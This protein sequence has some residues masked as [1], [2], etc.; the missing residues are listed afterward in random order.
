MKKFLKKIWAF[1]V[2]LFTNPEQWIENNIVPSIEVVQNIK[3]ALD[4]KIAILLTGLIPGQWDD[5]IRKKF[6]EHLAQVIFILTGIEH[7]ENMLPQ[8]IE[9]L[10]TLKPATRAAVYLKIASKMAQ[11]NGTDVTK[12]FSVDLLTQLTYSKQKSKVD[13]ENLEDVKEFEP[14]QIGSF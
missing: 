3:L 8:F 7:G 2:M 6:S 9:W 13:A 10:R 11:L 4:S 12:N 5:E 1:V 14:L